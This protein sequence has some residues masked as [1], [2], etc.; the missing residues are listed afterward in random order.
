MPLCMYTVYIRRVVLFFFKMAGKTLAWFVH[1]AAFR[2]RFLWHSKNNFYISHYSVTVSM[3]PSLTGSLSTSLSLSAYMC[4]L[5]AL[6]LPVMRALCSCQCGG[7]GKR[8]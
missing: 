3:S 2:L 8:R 6:L 7:V 4:V 1:A 5:S